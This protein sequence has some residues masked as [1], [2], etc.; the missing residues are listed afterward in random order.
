MKRFFLTLSFALC[1]ASAPQI[2]AI[3]YYFEVPLSGGQEF[4]GP[5]DADGTGLARLWFDSA[6][7]SVVW[8]ITVE[9]VA[10]PIAAA[11]IHNAPAGVA[12]PVRVDF[13]GMLAGG[14]VV[15]AD[16]A[17]ILANPLN[18]YVNVHNS[19]FPAGAVR[20]QLGTGRALPEHFG[21]GSTALALGL[22]LAAGARRRFEALA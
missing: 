3:V 20:G 14:P 12:G 10:L 16:I 17:G 21:L 13:M 15:D 6:A 2:Q 8:D 22:L 18:W 5:G 7:N 1:L 9:N 4:P 19:F 11:H